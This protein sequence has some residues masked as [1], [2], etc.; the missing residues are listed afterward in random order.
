MFRIAGH[1]PERGAAYTAHM[2]MLFHGGWD[3][4]VVALLFWAAIFGIP[5]VAVS[6]LIRFAYRHYASKKRQ[7]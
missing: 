7:P 4:I 6:L 2:L 5:V 3:T 1:S